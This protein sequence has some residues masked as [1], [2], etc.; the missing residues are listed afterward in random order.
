[1]AASGLVS[2]HFWYYAGDGNSHLGPAC[3]DAPALLLGVWFFLVFFVFCVLD[4]L[5]WRFD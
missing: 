2:Q 4:I 1:M 3:W 5:L